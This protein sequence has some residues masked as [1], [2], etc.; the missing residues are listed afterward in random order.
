MLQWI[1]GPRESVILV[2]VCTICPAGKTR[3]QVPQHCVGRV[4][5]KMGA[6]INEIQE[7]SNTDIKMNQEQGKLS[8]AYWRL[9]AEGALNTDGSRNTLG[10]Y[11]YDFFFALHH[12]TPELVLLKI[13]WYF[14]ERE[15]DP[16]IFTW[17][18]VMGAVR[19][20]D[21]QIISFWFHLTILQGS[22]SSRVT[23]LN[24]MRICHCMGHQDTKEAGYSYAGCPRLLMTLLD[25]VGSRFLRCKILRLKPPSIE[26]GHPHQ[27]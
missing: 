5:G 15:W 14:D 19:G 3:H 24:G 22:Q 17:W 4:L 10:V 11:W 25:S 20:C 1:L 26:W 6:T 2:A 23:G 7:A 18:E 9:I 12:Y 16:Q 21:T 8:K 27:H 13:C